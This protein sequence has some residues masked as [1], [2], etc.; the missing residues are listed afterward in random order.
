MP[1]ERAADLLLSLLLSVDAQMCIAL[2]SV[3]TLR[4]HNCTMGREIREHGWDRIRESSDDQ[5]GGIHHT[6]FGSFRY[7]NVG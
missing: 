5:T 2:F 6:N 3:R 7:C 1:S 4:P